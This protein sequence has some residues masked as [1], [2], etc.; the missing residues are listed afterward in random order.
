MIESALKFLKLGISVLPVRMTVDKDGNID[1]RPK[2]ASWKDL[3][4][5]AIPEESVPNIFQYA[6][7][8]GIIGG[9]VSGNLEIIDF[10][11]HG[12]IS[13]KL[14]NDFIGEE[15]VSSI[16]SKH[17]IPIER[18]IRGGYHVIY[19]CKEEIE[20]N[21]K[22][23]MIDIDDKAYTIIETRGEGGFVVC[24]PTDG[25]NI[26]S[27]DIY[28]IP[29]IEKEERDYII[30]LCKSYSQIEQK[31]IAK[32]EYPDES[33]INP[34]YQSE[35]YKPGDDY[36]YTA[37]AFTECEAILRH[38]GWTKVK[39]VYWRR[40]GKTDGISASFGKI[41][42]NGGVPLF[43]VFTS[44]AHPFDVD[45]TYTPF[46]LFTYLSYGTS[47]NDFSRAAKELYDRGGYGHDEKSAHDANK[48]IVETIIKEKKKGRKRSGDG[49]EENA[50]NEVTDTKEFLK[51]RFKFRYNVISNKVEYCP[52]S[53]ND[54]ETCNESN[55][56]VKTRES[57]ISIRKEAVVNILSSDYVEQYNPFIEYFKN[58]KKWDGVDY[59]KKLTEYIDVEYPDFFAGMLLKQFV[60]AIKCALED[61]FYNRFIFVLQ[62]RKQEL[63]KSRLIRFFNPFGTKYF[64]DEK[65]DKKTDSLISLTENFIYSLEEIDDMKEVGVGALKALLAKSHVNVRHP[66]GKQKVDKAR[67]CTFFGRT[68][69][70]EFLTDN[71]N[72]RWLIFRINDIDQDLFN[73]IDVNNLWSMAM[74]FYLKSIDGTYNWDL[75][76]PEK[77]S[78]EI[79]NRRY[80][81]TKLEE[82]AIIS[83][84][85]SD[86]TGHLTVYEV[87]KILANENGG[88]RLNLNGAFIND[89]LVTLGFDYDF[90]NFGKYFK[91]KHK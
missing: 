78:R 30:N 76:Q 17:N 8:I 88:V 53:S 50:K 25:Y 69:L 73:E 6:G 66:Y 49:D 61:E 28:N 58:V 60:R 64:T 18:T 81:Q 55:V 70:C 82:Q 71:I 44:N 86:E 23:C 67:C 57:G 56:W 79:M 2:I 46:T 15:R 7:G 39:D 84:F 54:F 40:P 12:D 22:L 1:K 45:K 21:Q 83:T 89:C 26:I 80:N 11:N 5:K 16:L 65:L 37:D 48:K 31:K 14:F 47:I 41:V 9:K 52:I 72:T 75:T 90:N 63:G 27:G 10:D 33:K 43:H 36:N 68:N 35:S 34:I 13:E 74:H 77:E 38:N 87:C 91:I 24:S 42:T 59:F 85:V 62:S 51:G 19:R 20:G 3:Q 4:I 32:Y 29:T